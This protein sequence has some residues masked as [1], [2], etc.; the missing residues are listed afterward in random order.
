M[1]LFRLYQIVRLREALRMWRK[2]AQR[3]RAGLARTSSLPGGGE[4]RRSSSTNG[5]SS[6]ARVPPGHLAVYV[7]QERERFVIKTSLLAHPLFR[8]LLK[9]TEE[10]IGFHYEGGLSIPCEVAAFR[11]LLAL[12]KGKRAAD[13][14]S[15]IMLKALSNHDNREQDPLLDVQDHHLE[16]HHVHSFHGLLSELLRIHI[17]DTSSRLPSRCCHGS[18]SSLMNGSVLQQLICG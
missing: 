17:M 15:M 10:E 2:S 4:S 16:E 14:M 9:K 5:G 8:A 13:T 3:S 6:S 12:M 18:R 7:G 1:S 11:R